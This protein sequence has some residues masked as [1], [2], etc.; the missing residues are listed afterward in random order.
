MKKAII[1]LSSVWIIVSCG[2][3]K[4][5]E[6]TTDADKKSTENATPAKN[7]EVE[8]GLALVGK[9][10]CFSC[11]K[12]SEQGVG[13]AYQAVAQKYQASPDV[14]DSLAAKVIKGGSGHWGAVPMTPHPSLSKDDAKAM[15][16][17]VLSLKQ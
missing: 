11:H 5:A 2:N 12:I 10:D 7:P 17:Y 6:S 15:V 14:I 13:P 1:I 16:T 9:S 8:K 4:S 3:N